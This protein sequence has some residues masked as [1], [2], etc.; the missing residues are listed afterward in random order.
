MRPARFCIPSATTFAHLFR[1]PPG[2]WR[3]RGAERAGPEAKVETSAMLGGGDHDRD[4]PTR[5]PSMAPV[6]ESRGRETERPGPGNSG[7]GGAVS[8]ILVGR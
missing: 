4:L 3:W 2:R 8:G 5:P 1:T 7:A 6:A